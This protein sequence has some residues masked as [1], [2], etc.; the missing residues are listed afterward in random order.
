[1]MLVC[2]QE[3]KSWTKYFSLKLHAAGVANLFL[4]VKAAGVA[5]PIVPMPVGPLATGRKNKRDSGHIARPQKEGKPTG[6]MRINEKIAYRK[7]RW[8]TQLPTP[9]HP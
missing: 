4:S 7:K 5:R 8:A 9:S 2:L 3:L 1:M 6:K